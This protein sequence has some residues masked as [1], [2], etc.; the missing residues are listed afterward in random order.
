MRT[1]GRGFSR[2]VGPRATKCGANLNNT[3]AS[4]SPQTCDTQLRPRLAQSETFL[5]SS[6]SHWWIRVVCTARPG[7]TGRAH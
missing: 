4:R 2:I 6:S 7:T 1:Q 3:E 5:P